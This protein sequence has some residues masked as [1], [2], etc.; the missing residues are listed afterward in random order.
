MDRPEFWGFGQR[1]SDGVGNG[2]EVVALRLSG[3]Q[4]LRC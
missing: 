3:V 4:V 1:F 2:V